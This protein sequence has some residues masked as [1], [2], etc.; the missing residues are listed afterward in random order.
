MNDESSRSHMIIIITVSQTNNFDLTVKVGKLYL[1]DLAGSE[2]L[3]KSGFG[4]V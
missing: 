1:V 3:S 4:S 2:K